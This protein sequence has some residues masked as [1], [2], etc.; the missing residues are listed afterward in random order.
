[1]LESRFETSKIIK[2]EIF[3]LII[4]IALLIFLSREYDLINISILYLLK[5][6][7]FVF[8]RF[9][10]LNRF[11]KIKIKILYFLLFFLILNL[12][13]YYYWNIY[14]YIIGFTILILNLLYLK[15]NVF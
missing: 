2:I 5:E 10:Y 8:I 4:H 14:I 13:N 9:F 11:Y 15:K 6:I 7:T 1:M 3:Y 12:L